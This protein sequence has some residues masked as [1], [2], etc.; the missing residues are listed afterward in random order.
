[1]PN[2][3]VIAM[4]TIVVYAAY[5]FGRYS[6]RKDVENGIYRKSITRAGERAGK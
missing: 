1:M 6:M 3:Y 4:A 5:R 2:E